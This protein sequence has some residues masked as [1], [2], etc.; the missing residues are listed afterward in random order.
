[1]SDIPSNVILKHQSI[2]LISVELHVSPK[3]QIICINFISQLVNEP[4][5]CK[6]NT[7]DLILTNVPHRVQ[8]IQVQSLGSHLQSDHFLISASILSSPFRVCSMIM[9]NKPTDCPLNYSK[10]D[11]QGLV[12]HATN[13]LESLEQ[14]LIGIN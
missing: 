14:H 9:P 11:N 12:N 3:I 6:G 2:E 5:H 10:V 7:L 13:L 1:M 8:N 4:T